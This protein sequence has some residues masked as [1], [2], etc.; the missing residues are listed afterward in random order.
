MITDRLDTNFITFVEESVTVDGVKLDTTKYTWDSSTEKLT[1]HLEDVSVNTKKQLPFKFLKNNVKSY[2]FCSFYS[3]TVQIIFVSY[4]IP[5]I[6]LSVIINNIP[7]SSFQVT[8]VFKVLSSFF[9][10][11]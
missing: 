5:F 4:S 9:L 11:V 1:I 3:S 6:N 2:Q 10:P 7:S 8:L